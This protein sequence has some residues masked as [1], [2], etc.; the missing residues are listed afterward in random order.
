[1]YKVLIID[2]EEPV[3]EAIKIL[4]QWET[5][6]VNEVIEAINGKEGIKLVREK[7]PD[8]VLV[9]MKM[10]EMNGLEFLIM[11]QAE[12]P[13]IQ[14]IVVS[15]YNSYEYTRQAIQSKATDYL[16]KP[17]NREE[18]NNTILK[19]I[20][21]ISKKRQEHNEIIDNDIM[22]NVS[23]PVLKEKIFMSII[24][25]SFDNA[26]KDLY[27]NMI[28]I[29]GKTKYF[30]VALIRIM[31]MEELVNKKFGN[32]VNLMHLA[33]CNVINEIGNQNME[34]FSFANP[35]LEREI[36]VIISC[37]GISQNN[38]DLLYYDAIKKI[39]QELK[40]LL[41]LKVA[42]CI[43]KNYIGIESL[44]ESY[45]SAKSILNSINVIDMKEEIY[46]GTLENVKVEVSSIFNNIA[47][48]KNA[49]E[50]GSAIYLRSI[51][52]EYIS[53]VRA[54][55]Y[56]S[57]KDAHKTL[58]E[59]IILMEEVSLSFGF[60]DNSISEGG[61]K[62]ANGLNYDFSTFPE[63]ENI[64][65][66]IVDFYYT[67]VRKCIRANENFNVGEI[68]DYIDKN[69]SQ[70]I[71]ISMFTDR[72]YLSREYI[73]KLFKQE[74]GCGIHEYIQDVRMKK[75]KEFLNDMQIKIQNISQI[76]GYSDT[77]YFSKAFKN[78]YGVSPTDYRSINLN[79]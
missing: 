20:N 23:L 39:L 6:Q 79:K 74:Y 78:F 32:D 9:D 72:Y 1:M 26:D 35:I 4:G 7:K 43:G 12:Y 45:K 70:E 52:S 18:L 44:S 54:V 24:E 67:E 46:N 38:I 69:Y 27:L 5:L 8:I 16:L 22:L 63:F 68:K 50:K 28:D 30:G 17:I 53:K 48:I 55:G 10:P 71:K 57:F 33:L 66:N 62:E 59:F 11:L 29:N 58:K 51:I 25:G 73:M 41:K 64:L 13:D 14:T 49:F 19:C 47:I 3:R 37:V 77:N 34:C 76:L 61:R 60:P 36:V 40:Q 31:N 21:I 56:F 42:I 75:A 65:Y 2:D 15:G